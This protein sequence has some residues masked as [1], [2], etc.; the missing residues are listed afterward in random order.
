MAPRS[1]WVLGSKHLCGVSAFLPGLCG[2]SP[3]T[4]ASSHSPAALGVRLMGDY[5][6][7][8]G[9]GVRVNGC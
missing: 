3:G 2:F 9:V 6:A 4:P 8:R 7:R 5:I 1:K